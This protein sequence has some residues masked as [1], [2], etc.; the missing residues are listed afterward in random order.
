M[1]MTNILL[2]EQLLEIA[3]NALARKISISLNKKIER[4]LI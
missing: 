1:P 3:E 2:R 4:K